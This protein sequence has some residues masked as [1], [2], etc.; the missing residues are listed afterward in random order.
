[1][2]LTETNPEKTPEKFYSRFDGTAQ[3]WIETEVFPAADHVTLR[4]KAKEGWQELSFF[5]DRLEIHHV[6]LGGEGQE[7]SELVGVG[8]IY[9]EYLDWD[10][11][12]W[13]HYSFGDASISNLDDHTL[14]AAQVDGDVSLI[15]EAEW[16]IGSAKQT[17]TASYPGQRIRISGVVKVLSDELVIDYSDFLGTDLVD[18]QEQ[19]IN[20]ET[21]RFLKFASDGVLSSLEVDPYLSVAEPTDAV[22]VGGD[23]YMY[24]MST[25]AENSSTGFNKLHYGGV[26]DNYV[27][28]ILG[29]YRDSS[30]VFWN[31]FQDPTRITTIEENN[32]TKVVIKVVGNLHNGSTYLSNSVSFTLIFYCYSDRM[33]IEVVWVTSGGNISHY[34]HA[35]YDSFLGVQDGD[36]SGAA[37]YTA[38][39][40]ETIV[41][42]RSDHTAADYMLM[43]ATEGDAQIVIIDQSTE[44]GAFVQYFDPTYGWHAAFIGTA[45]PGTH[46]MAGM[47]VIDSGAREHGSKLY[48]STDRLAMGE[49]YKDQDLTLIVGTAR[50][51]LTEPASIGSS[52]FASDGAWHLEMS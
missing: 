9:L 12:E 40:T 17:Y 31:I 27:V 22:Q 32:S 44:G 36:V 37:Y 4:R 35:A 50:T 13:V 39:P 47:L 42:S 34:S 18:D 7:V 38:Q 5:A 29:R 23:G 24:S 3:A 48:T 6:T 33:T 8:Q 43:T 19:T 14:R 25:D 1:M 28:P 49:Q 20:G 52:G 51:G 16:K 45:T 26:L 41:T 2:Q 30:G 11:N 15:V 21:Y 10:A 46:R